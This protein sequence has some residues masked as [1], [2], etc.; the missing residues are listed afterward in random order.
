S[1]R[2]LKARRGM[3]RTQA[4]IQS[5]LRA[6]LTSTNVQPHLQDNFVTVREGRYCLPVRAESRNS[7]PGIIHDRSGSGGAFFIEPQAV[8]ELNNRLRELALEEREAIREILQDLSARVGEVAG[9]LKSSSAACAELDFTFAKARLSL[10][11]Q[12]TAPLLGKAGFNL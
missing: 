8:V 1:L 12:A 10:K 6:M 2:L 7:V 4:E 3:A 5:K 11:Q 9:E